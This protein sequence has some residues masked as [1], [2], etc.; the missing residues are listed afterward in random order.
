MERNAISMDWKIQYYEDFQTDP[1][2]MQ[3]KS[4][5]GYFIKIDKLMPTL[6][7]A[8]EKEQS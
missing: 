8:S 5:A 6:K 2:S 7:T 3:S 1:E 4:Q